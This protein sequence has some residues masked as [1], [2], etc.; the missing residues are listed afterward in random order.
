MTMVAQTEDL[1]GSLAFTA[2]S[3]VL[4]FL[5]AT[6]RTG[7]LWIES[8]PDNR[9]A[10]VYFER[11]NVYHIQE[12]DTVGID[13][14]VEIISWS[15]GAFRFTTDTMVPIVSIEVSLPNALVEATRRVDEQR[16]LEA[17]QNQIDAPQ[18][19]LTA[20]ADSSGVL[21]AVLMARDGEVMAS[22]NPADE[23]DMEALS[24][25]L[26]P[27]IDTIDQLGAAQGCDP[28]GDFFVEFDQIQILCLPVAQAVVVVVA[29]G[30]AKLGVIRHK[31]QHL[32][33]S[34]AEVLTD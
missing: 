27:L 17:E 3:D 18:R 14:L 13:A 32:A 2:L 26:T 22:A 20:F 1:R 31:T 34:L 21:A 24:A 33:D 19:L 5:N 8:G 28:F 10:R 4:Q 6:G 7:E 23:V 30:Q 15:E 25:G 16:R 9:E 29:P 11:G 12:S